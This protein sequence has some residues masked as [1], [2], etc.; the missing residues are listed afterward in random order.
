MVRQVIRLVSVLSLLAGLIS[1]QAVQA[2]GAPLRTGSADPVN[3]VPEQQPVD[4]AKVAVGSSAETPLPPEG[5]PRRK[6][7]WHELG[8]EF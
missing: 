8:Q 4:P 3:S 2:T 5:S 1:A 6:D 7:I